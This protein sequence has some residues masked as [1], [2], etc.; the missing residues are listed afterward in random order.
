MQ[1]QY[2]LQS[3]LKIVY[4]FNYPTL[5]WDI[6]FQCSWWAFNLFKNTWK[7]HKSSASVHVFHLH[8]WWKKKISYAYLPVIT[9]IRKITGN[10]FQDLVVETCCGVDRYNHRKYLPNDCHK[11]ND[12]V[13][14][15]LSLLIVHVMGK[16]KWE[17]N[18]QT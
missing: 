4:S 17:Q 10:N 3:V 13:N 11:Y 18:K 16:R 14:Q 5:F 8:I 1:L 12:C 6:S 9:I 15:S 2:Q 7:P